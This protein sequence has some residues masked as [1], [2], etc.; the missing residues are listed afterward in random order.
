MAWTLENA[1]KAAN[2]KLLGSLTPRT[3]TSSVV[4]DSNQPTRQGIYA[5]GQFRT[6]VSGEREEANAILQ[7]NE[8][9][10]VAALG[11]DAAATVSTFGE[12][13]ED[14]LVINA[15]HR[16][17]FALE[18]NSLPAPADVITVTLKYLQRDAGQASF[19]QTATVNVTVTGS[20]TLETLAADI[21]SGLLAQ[22][23]SF[24]DLFIGEF[25]P[26]P[27]VGHTT[28]GAVKD[29]KFISWVE[30]NTGLS[31]TW[32]VMTHALSHE[33]NMS[34]MTVSQ[35]SAGT[36]LVVTTHRASET[37][38]LDTNKLR[39]TRFS[40]SSAM[41]AGETEHLP[42]M[43]RLDVDAQG[44]KLRSKQGAEQ[45]YSGLANQWSEGGGGVDQI[46]VELSPEIITP[47]VMRSARIELNYDQ[48]AAS[49]VL[50]A[51]ENDFAATALPWPSLNY[52]SEGPIVV[53][54]LFVEPH[55][56][57]VDDN[58]AGGS[59]DLTMDI[60]LR[61]PDLLPKPLQGN[62]PLMSELASGRSAW[63]NMLRGFPANTLPNNRLWGANILPKGPTYFHSARIP[64]AEGEDYLTTDERWM[65]W[66]QENVDGAVI[67]T[68][69]LVPSAGPYTNDFI[70]EGWEIEYQHASQNLGVSVGDPLTAEIY[71][72]PPGVPNIPANYTALSSVFP[73]TSQLYLW[74]ASNDG[75]IKIDGSLGLTPGSRY[76]NPNMGF[77]LPAGYKIAVNLTYPTATGIV[78][79]S[80]YFKVILNAH[81]HTGKGSALIGNQTITVN[82][83]TAAAFTPYLF[84]TISRKGF[85]EADVANPNP[86]NDIKANLTAGKCYV[87][88]HFWQPH[89]HVTAVDWAGSWP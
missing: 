59:Y 40:S 10:E 2:A 19:L 66:D 76:F 12:T 33:Q 28:T 38:R 89:R 18:L 7:L 51:P 69:G 42:A 23:D 17:L 35:S 34:V 65:W 75:K 13:A 36:D 41:A 45:N 60:G 52:Y 62:Y 37:G 50:A 25:L 56:A 72:C 46:T 88:V 79:Q 78:P 44:V 30:P 53:T 43:F 67:E 15:A 5:G 68:A 83:Y 82:P 6:N 4:V 80:S 27:T 85:G 49:S 31:G 26:V 9:V 11:K 24:S 57:F 61:T 74:N 1:L 39:D 77:R 32:S 3:T 16:V 55:T 47:G 84:A 58:G 64:F 20:H 54:D 21:H 48:F 71:I 14:R 87:H 73:T 70:I 22:T 86:G 8:V 29:G 81:R 63:S